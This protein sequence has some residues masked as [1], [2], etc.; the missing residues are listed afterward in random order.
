MPAS[1]S[2]CMYTST[3]ISFALSGIILGI[4]IDYNEVPGYPNP[5]PEKEVP[6]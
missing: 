1:Y 3:S 6:G 2:D 4:V 5:N